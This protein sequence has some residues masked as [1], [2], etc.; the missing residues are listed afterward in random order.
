MK[1]YY[2]L[3][4]NW[5]LNKTSKNTLMTLIPFLQSKNFV[6][7]LKL[8][9]VEI[10]WGIFAVFTQTHTLPGKSWLIIFVLVFHLTFIQILDKKQSPY[11]DA[12]FW[13]AIAMTSKYWSPFRL[14]FQKCA[15]AQW[16]VLLVLFL[17]PLEKLGTSVS[18]ITL[19][20]IPPLTIYFTVWRKFEIAGNVSQGAY[21][22]VD[23][24]MRNF[25]L[26]FVEIKCKSKL[27]F[28]LAILRNFFCI[29]FLWLLRITLYFWTLSNSLYYNFLSLHFMYF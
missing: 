2:W 26:M 7:F 12:N 3:L 15:R 1:R 19:Y 8:E 29:V 16:G 22:S 6:I 14:R 9:L 11:H 23:K 13:Q 5:I 18:T 20:D 28:P 25:N 21:D 27:S 10:D 4:K 17:W 24:N